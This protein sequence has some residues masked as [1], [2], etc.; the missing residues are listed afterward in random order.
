M[1]GATLINL[2]GAIH[3]MYPIADAL[4]VGIY[5]DSWHTDRYGVRLSAKL[6]LDLYE[7]D[8]ALERPGYHI[9][10]VD[11]YGWS[12]HHKLSSQDTV[13]LDEQEYELGSLR[14]TLSRGN[15]TKAETHSAQEELIALYE[16]ICRDAER[17]DIEPVEV[18]YLRMEYYLCST[19]VPSW[20]EEEV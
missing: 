8:T 20:G 1:P 9:V 4:Q 10:D 15:L 12:Y 6:L 2:L 19:G 17:Y 7:V 11:Q 3:G 16:T 5:S 14:L 13:E 18:D